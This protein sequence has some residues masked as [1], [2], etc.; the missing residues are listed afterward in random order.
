M[1]LALL[2]LLYYYFI[3]II[4]TPHFYVIFIECWTGP[5]SPVPIQPSHGDEVHHQH[6]QPQWD[7]ITESADHHQPVPTQRTVEPKHGRTQHRPYFPITTCQQVRHS[8]SLQLHQR[9]RPGRWQQGEQRVRNDLDAV[10][11]IWWTFLLEAPRFTVN[12]CAYIYNKCIH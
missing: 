9:R 1:Q 6:E 11:A 10:Q 8:L 5:S 2:K 12:S 3:T 7:A 4:T